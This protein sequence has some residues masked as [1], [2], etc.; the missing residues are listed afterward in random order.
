MAEIPHEWR[1]YAS[2]QAELSNRSSVDSHSW[3]LEAGLNGLLDGT[4]SPSEVDT[5][6]ASA[7]RQSRYAAAL[8]A[9]YVRKDVSFDPLPQL[10]A[11]STLHAIGE[12][13]TSSHVGVLVAAIEGTSMDGASRTKLSRARIA[14]RKFA[15]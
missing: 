15:A 8:I 2:K 7:S 9:K 5:T 4:A 13:M 1:A 12:T 3:G 14:A 11:R 10:L 6:I